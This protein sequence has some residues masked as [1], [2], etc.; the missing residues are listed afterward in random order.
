MSQLSMFDALVMAITPSVPVSDLTAARALPAVVS[1][2][3]RK[4]RG[5]RGRLSLM[6]SARQRR[7]CGAVRSFVILSLWRPANWTWSVFTPRK[8]GRAAAR[9]PP[10]IN[11]RISTGCIHSFLSWSMRCLRRT[12]IF[13][14]RCTWS[15]GWVQMR[16]GNTSHLMGPC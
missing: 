16:W 12:R 8:A 6:N 2:P 13:W 10:A 1:V 9:L 11:R 14:G 3:A 5:K 7:I 15:S 4:V